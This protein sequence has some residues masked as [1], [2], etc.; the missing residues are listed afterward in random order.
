VEGVQQTREEGE[1]STKPFKTR[2]GKFQV[3]CTGANCTYEV[4]LGFR[5]DSASNYKVI[6]RSRGKA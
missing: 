5:A 4:L 1:F 2:G 6:G 3:K